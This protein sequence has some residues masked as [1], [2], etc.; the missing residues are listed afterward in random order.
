MKTRILALFLLIIVAC[1]PKDQGKGSAILK[2]KE[3]GKTV[4]DFY[5][6][7]VDT[8]SFRSFR[9]STSPASDLRSNQPVDLTISDT[10]TLTWGYHEGISL[11]SENVPGKLLHLMCLD[12]PK[13]L[14][15]TL[16]VINDSILSCYNCIRE[17]KIVLR[18]FATLKPEDGSSCPCSGLP[19]YFTQKYFNGN[20]KL[21][22]I[23]GIDSASEV[24]FRNSCQVSGF[25]D[26]NEYN[27]P[28]D[29]YGS[30]TNLD[31][32]QFVKKEGE[33]YT[34]NKFEY[35]HYKIK[36]DS[37]YLYDF[38]PPYDSISRDTSNEISDAKIGELKA[39]L[40]KI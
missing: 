10:S 3:N 13:E 19:C 1:Q 17:K 34:K 20:F 36:K 32:I 38:E 29:D 23:K 22:N 27:I 26:Y 31:V 21:V 18:K 35:L 15:I 40:K 14:S 9:N 30:F 5:G 39:I 37:I 25:K 4:S 28:F 33:D 11:V 16:D 7:W 8:E 12:N 24:T 6:V 2:S